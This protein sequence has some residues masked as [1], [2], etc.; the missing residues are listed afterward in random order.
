MM[1]MLNIVEVGEKRDIPKKLENEQKS[2]V[3]MNKGN[4]SSDLPYLLI[5]GKILA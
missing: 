1:E 3:I 2:S 4:N 5:C